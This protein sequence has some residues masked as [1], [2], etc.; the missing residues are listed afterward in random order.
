MW[1]SHSIL[2]ARP[3][4]SACVPRLHVRAVRPGRH[5][6]PSPNPKPSPQRGWS[7]DG[8]NPLFA[9]MGSC[10]GLEAG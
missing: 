5:K 4:D 9:G 10:G 7:T 1:H 2:G 6:N 8:S 3:Y